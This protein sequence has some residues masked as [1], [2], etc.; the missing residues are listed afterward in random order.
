MRGKCTSLVAGRQM[1]SCRR[2]DFF[3]R[4]FNDSKVPDLSAS[5]PTGSIR[6]AGRSSFIYQFV[7]LVGQ[8]RIQSFQDLVLI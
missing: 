6:H 5:G 4:V 7:E 3:L 8:L 2:M 1:F